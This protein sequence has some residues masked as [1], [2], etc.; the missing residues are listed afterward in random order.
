YHVMAVEPN[1][2]R[3]P[4]LPITDTLR[5]VRESDLLVFLVNHKE[6]QGLPVADKQVLDFCGVTRF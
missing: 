2:R 5:A 6:F 4:R 1:L 3:H